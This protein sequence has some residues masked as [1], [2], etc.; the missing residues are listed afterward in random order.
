VVVDC[1][2]PRALAD[3][4]RQLVGGVLDEATA[5]ADWVALREF[6]E[7]GYLGFQRVPEMKLTKNRV[8]LDVIVD[9]LGI[10]IARGKAL[11]AR[12]LGNV[13]DEALYQFQVMSDPEGNEFCFVFRK[14]GP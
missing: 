7:L 5:T 6:P 9:D 10:A 3:F 2:D 8:H 11:G 12:A 14:P 1:S 13:V 4:W